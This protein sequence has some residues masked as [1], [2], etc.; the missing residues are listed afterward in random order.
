MWTQ[1]MAPGLAGW[2][3]QGIGRSGLVAA[4][5][6]VMKGWSPRAA[7]EKVTAG[8]GIAVPETVEQRHW[9]DHYAAV[10]SGTR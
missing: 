8:R 5:L 9:L 3:R 6:L 2:R 10:L 7:V 1:L 4:C